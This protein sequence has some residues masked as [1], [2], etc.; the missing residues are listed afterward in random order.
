M[1]FTLTL[2]PVLTTSST[3]AIRLS[4]SLLIWIMPD[5]LPPRSTMAPTPSKIFTT[6]PSNSC[7]TSI[8]RT[9]FSMAFFACSHCSLLSPVMT[10]T[11]SSAIEIS[12]AKS[13]CIAWIV[14]PPLPITIQILSTGIRREIRAGARGETSARGFSRALSMPCIIVSRLPFA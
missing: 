1:T 2:S 13:F 8:S 3:R 14:S 5:L 6:V 10:T 12:T 4:D 7:P 11:P 9:I